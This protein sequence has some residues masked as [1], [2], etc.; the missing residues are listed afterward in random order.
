MAVI[1]GT[2]GGLLALVFVAG[3][4]W[5]IHKDKQRDRKAKAQPSP[6]SEAAEQAQ[7]APTQT[8]EVSPHL[9]SA[10]SS[11][12]RLVPMESEPDIQEVAR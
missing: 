11:Q 6:S 9:A 10:P 1:A 8:V 2:A 3:S 12:A 7:M 4:C 5:H